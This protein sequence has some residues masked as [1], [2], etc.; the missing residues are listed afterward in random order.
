MLLDRLWSPRK[1]QP[2]NIKMPPIKAVSG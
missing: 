1:G 2:L